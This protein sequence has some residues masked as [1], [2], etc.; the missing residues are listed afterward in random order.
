MKN[1]TIFYVI[2]DEQGRFFWQEGIY[3]AYTDKGFKEGLENAYLFRNRKI[4]EQIQTLQ[5]EKSTIREVI[6]TLNTE[7][8]I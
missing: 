3:L 6:L 4:A 1:K 7:H 2:Q 5:K 8:E